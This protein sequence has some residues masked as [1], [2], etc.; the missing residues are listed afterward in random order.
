[1]RLSMR[2]KGGIKPGRLK[3]WKTTHL[4]EIQRSAI[5]QILSSLKT[6]HNEDFITC[7]K[8]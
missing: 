6:K 1:M 8:V 5:A 4:F 2:K 7:V 3:L